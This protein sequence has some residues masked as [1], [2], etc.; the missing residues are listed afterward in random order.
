MKLQQSTP[1]DQCDMFL[2]QQFTPQFKLNFMHKQL[3]INDLVNDL[4]MT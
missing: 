2:S 1:S 3:D 4:S